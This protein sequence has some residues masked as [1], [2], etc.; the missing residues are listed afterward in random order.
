VTTT[1]MAVQRFDTATRSAEAPDA[2]ASGQ[3]GGMQVSLC[4]LSRREALMRTVP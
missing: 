4:A 3:S 1:G 2:T